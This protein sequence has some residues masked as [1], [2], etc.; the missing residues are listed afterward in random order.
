MYSFNLSMKALTLSNFSARYIGMCVRP[1]GEE[2]RDRFVEQF[3]FYRLYCGLLSRNRRKKSQKSM[4]MQKR[5]VISYRLREK[6][7][8]G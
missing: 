3:R 4:S 8:T 6:L 2:K 7:L 5:F 1:S